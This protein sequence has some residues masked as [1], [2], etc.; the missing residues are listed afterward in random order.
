MVQCTNGTK[1]A[2]A[3]RIPSGKRFNCWTGATQYV[4][5]VTSAETFVTMPAQAITLTATFMTEAMPWL[6]LL[7]E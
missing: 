3:A 5:S 7:L 6:N 2:I 1:V 4:D